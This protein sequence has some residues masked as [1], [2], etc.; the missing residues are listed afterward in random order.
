MRKNLPDWVAPWELARSGQRLQGQ[1]AFAQMLRLAQEFL[2]EEG[3]AQVELVFDCDK[4]AGRCFVQG[5]IKA[6]LPL[7]CQRCLRP[8]ELPL[9]V[10]TQLGLM[11]AESEID[12]WPDDYEP[13]IVNPEEQASLWR[14]VE[15]E[16]FLALPIVARHP[17]GECRQQ[18]LAGNEE[19]AETARGDRENPFAALKKF[20]TKDKNSS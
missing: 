3:I 7:T 2:I 18:V 9:D 10:H 15:D 20:K 16:L 5:R 1:V 17:L 12:R 8:L 6:R 11:V 4:A 14:L 19:P 13:W